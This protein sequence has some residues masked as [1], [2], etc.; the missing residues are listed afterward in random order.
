MA[1]RA[2]HGA[3]S[4]CCA[5]TYLTLGFG[6]RRALVQFMHNGG[7]AAFPQIKRKLQSYLSDELFNMVSGNTGTVVNPLSL[8]SLGLMPCPLIPS[9]I[10]PFG[11]CQFM[12]VSA[13]D[14]PPCIQLRTQAIPLF[15]TEPIIWRNI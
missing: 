7:V 14:I 5:S 10:G 6:L 9:L 3:S 1:I 12:L 8:G 13:E 15:R 4:E 11:L 2:N